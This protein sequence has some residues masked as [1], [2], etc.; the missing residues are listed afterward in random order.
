[1][2]INLTVFAAPV[3]LVLIG[4]EFFLTYHKKSG[5]YQLNDSINN[6]SAGIF[7]EIAAL[8]VRGLVIFSYYYLYEHF[9]F[10]HIKP[11]LVSS[12]ILLWLSVDFCYYWYHRTS[13]RCVFFWI[14]HSVHHQ[15]EHYNLSVALRQG[16]WQTLTSWVFYLPLALIGFPTWMFVIVSSC[17]TIYQF[18]IHTQSINKMGWFEIIFNTPSHHRVHHGKNPQY[19]DKN[20]AGSL[21]I[22]DKLFGTFEP[23]ETPAEY[24]VTEPLDSWNPFYANIKVIK[25]VMYYGKNLKN[26]VDVVRAFFMP[27]EWIMNRLQQEGQT[28]S[29]QAV[30]QKNFNS[31]KLY[32]LFNTAL[33]IAL[34]A[35]LSFI[36]KLNSLNSWLIGAF[37]LFTLYILG[38]VANGKQKILFIELSRSI[39]VLFTLVAFKINLFL[40]L[41]ISL[42]FL[43]INLRLFSS[44]FTQNHSYTPSISV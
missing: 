35:Y 30:P 15:S 42:L 34:Y 31:P 19:I 4:L 27:P 25:D 12:W 22:W 37:I 6:F 17:N 33:A 8:P 29:K 16:Y 39:L 41:L 18:W 13:H 32:L 10:F 11:N 21:I 40:S 43:L 23:E 1:M 44:H 20:Y 9:A 7:E 2:E 14:G 5:I 38:A 36:F 28:V 24:G 3:F 26:K